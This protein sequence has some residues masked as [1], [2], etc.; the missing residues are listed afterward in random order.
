M[1]RSGAFTEVGGDVVL[2]RAFCA[3]QLADGLRYCA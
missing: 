1:R 3:A 2:R